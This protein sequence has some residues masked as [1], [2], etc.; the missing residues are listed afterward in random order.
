MAVTQTLRDRLADAINRGI[1]S[2]EHDGK[3]VTYRSLAEMRQILAS[4][5][6]QLRSPRSTAHFARFNRGDH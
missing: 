2:V 4:M 6:R 3:K 1:T 5:D